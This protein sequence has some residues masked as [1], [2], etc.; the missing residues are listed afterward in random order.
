M[1]TGVRAGWILCGKQT[2]A[3]MCANSRLRVGNVR[4]N[5]SAALDFAMPFGGL[6]Q[7]GWGR[8][9]GFEGVNAFLESKSV[10]IALQ[11]E[12]AE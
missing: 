10:Y 11:Q 9:N 2:K 1:A 4:V 6:K 8:E 3:R 7:S 12:M 5:A